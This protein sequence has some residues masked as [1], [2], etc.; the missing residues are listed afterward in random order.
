MAQLIDSPTT[1]HIQPMQIDTKNRH[2]NGTDFKADLLPKSSAAPPNASYSG[3]LECP[4][5]T[6]IHK[7]INITYATENQGTCDTLVDRPSECFKA[8]VN[9]DPSLS[10]QTLHVLESAKYP[11]G[12]SVIRFQNGSSDVILN[13]HTQGAIC[14]A[15]GNQWLG[16]STSITTLVTFDLFLDKTTEKAMMNITGPDG[17]WFGVGIGAKTFTM[18]DQPYS[19]VIDGSGTVTEL[20]LGNHDGGEPISQSIQVISNKVTDGLRTVVLERTFKGQ[21]PD[22]YTF[23]PSTTSTIPIITAS[24]TGSKYS[25]HGP[26]HR[27]G[28]SIHLMGIDTSTCICNIG[29]KGSI[30]GV[31]FSKNCLPEPAADL[32]QQKNPTCWVN[33]YE[34]GLS[35]CHHKTVLLDE[36]QEQPEGFMTYHLKFRFYFQPYEPKTDTNSA[37]HQNLIRFFVE[38]EAWAGEYDIPKADPTTPPEESVYQIT[39][40]WKVSNISSNE[41]FN[42]NL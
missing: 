24:G 42:L 18:S 35:C 28:A 9:L 20:K 8:A 31:P 30:N 3:L 16:S 22:H 7:V 34:G 17:K 13:K 25:Y 4:C 1:F 23:D 21:T 27:S 33:T 40:R 29:I 6:R 26:T 37:S 11:S 36:D 10:N 2:Y 19:I 12:C 41:I 38:T 15:G 32:A 5:T 14:G 39:A